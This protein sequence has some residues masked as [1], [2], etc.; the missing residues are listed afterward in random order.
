MEIQIIGKEYFYKVTNG[1]KNFVK[2]HKKEKCEIDKNVTFPSDK[3]YAEYNN[4][5]FVLIPSLRVLLI[6]ANYK[7]AIRNKLAEEIFNQPSQFVTKNWK[8]VKLSD[9]T[10]K[11]LSQLIGFNT[12]IQDNEFYLPIKDS[13]ET[14]NYLLTRYSGN[15]IQEVE[16][17]EIQIYQQKQTGTVTHGLHIFSYTNRLSMSFSEV[18]YY[19]KF[20]C[21]LL[22]DLKIL[23]Q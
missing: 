10:G 7:E 20:F 14:G 13:I 12:L 3:I 8:I 2:Y 22:T 15:Q 19:D 21:K 5:Y 1:F 16:Q 23:H 9:E 4:M 6:P 17:Y 11:N 18:T